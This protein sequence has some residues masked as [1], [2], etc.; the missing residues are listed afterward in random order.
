MPTIPNRESDLARPRARKGGDQQETK[1]GQLRPVTI[2]DP[3]P[4]W[5]Y[6]VQ[7]FWESLQNSGQSDFFQDSDW[8]FAY[9]VAEDLHQYKYGTWTDKDGNEHPLKRNGQILNTIYAAMGSL[10]VTEG[11]RRRLR[12]ELTA[13]PTGESEA[14]V[15]ALADYRAELGLV[16]PLD[17]S[18]DE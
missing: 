5:G 8:A 1:H 12:V 4:E 17:E 18:D 9:S 10:L 14:S 2:P 11:D 16:P 3:D 13:P 15:T 7:L 6:I